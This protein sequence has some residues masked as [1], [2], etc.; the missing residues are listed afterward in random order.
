M[1]YYSVIK[2][3]EAML[4][5]TTWIYLENIVLSKMCQTMTNT[6]CYHLNWNLKY[7]STNEYNKP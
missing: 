1:K 5:A 7:N 3:N 6:V 4:F 2:E